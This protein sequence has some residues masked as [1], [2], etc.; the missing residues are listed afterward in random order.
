MENTS[1]TFLKACAILEG[2]VIDLLA[3][4]WEEAPRRHALEMAVALR[5][6]AHE[7]AWWDAESELK[8]VESLLSLSSHEALA[9][10]AAIASRLLEYMG[11]LKKLPVSR[12]A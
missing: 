1:T 10:R 7:A 9:I 5:H 11:L 2:A 12:S 8:A 4:S 6:V 3:G